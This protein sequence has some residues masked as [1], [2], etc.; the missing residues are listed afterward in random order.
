MVGIPRA[1]AGLVDALLHNTHDGRP[2]GPLSAGA[3]E[4]RMLLET[5]N[6]QYEKN[7]TSKESP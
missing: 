5:A 3:I 1:N 2:I 4:A 6:A 7:K